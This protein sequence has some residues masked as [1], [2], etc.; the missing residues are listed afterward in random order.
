MRFVKDWCFCLTH[1]IPVCRNVDFQRKGLFVN[2]L[3]SLSRRISSI[4]RFPSFPS[5]RRGDGP[6]FLS[7][8]FPLKVHRHNFR[9]PLFLHGDA[10]QGLGE[11]HGA[12][13]VGY[14]DNLG[15]FSDN[16]Q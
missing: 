9:N 3:S 7:I 1:G 13:V 5:N 15:F 11:F 2:I 8:L 16:L 6:A 4:I 10:E 14:H 12:L